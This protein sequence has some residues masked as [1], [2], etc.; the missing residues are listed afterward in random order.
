M[1]SFSA[2]RVFDTRGNALSQRRPLGS[3]ARDDTGDD[4]VE[5]RLFDRVFEQHPAT[6]FELPADL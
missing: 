5:D 1:R 2:P 6:S 4:A 3:D